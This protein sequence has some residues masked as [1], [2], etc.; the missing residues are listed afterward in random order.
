MPEK[1]LKCMRAGG[2][3]RTKKLSGDRYIHLCFKDGRSYVGE[4]KIKKK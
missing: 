4:L 3:V 1:F 2:R